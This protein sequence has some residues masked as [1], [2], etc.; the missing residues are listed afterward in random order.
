MRRLH[1]DGKPI[2]RIFPCQERFFKTVSPP[3]YTACTMCPQRLVLPISDNGLH[4]PV[5]SEKN[6]SKRFKIRGAPS[7]AGQ[8]WEKAFRER[9]P[10]GGQD[11]PP[12]I[13]GHR[14][15]AGQR[16]DHV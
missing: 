8:G 9:I 6:E 16:Q 2:R 11:D 3:W 5:W 12:R 4:H 13:G 7:P 14:E 15:G 10:G 1:V